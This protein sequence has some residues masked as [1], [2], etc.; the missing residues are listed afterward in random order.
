ME[1]S[2][3]SF[4]QKL[5]LGEDLH[6]R[7]EAPS[8]LLLRFTYEQ[9]VVR[10]LLGDQPAGMLSPRTLKDNRYTHEGQGC[11]YRRRPPPNSTHV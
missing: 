1:F 11:W 8:L 3:P 6:V 10:C 7:T 5:G 9:S 2:P 4:E